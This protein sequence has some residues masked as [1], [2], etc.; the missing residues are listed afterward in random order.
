MSD[1]VWN[2]LVRSLTGV[3]FML[4]GGYWYTHVEEFLA[5]YRDRPKASVETIIPVARRMVPIMAALLFLGGSI[6][7]GWSIVQAVLLLFH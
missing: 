3:L 4:I 6:A 5:I 2:M 1:H 7:L